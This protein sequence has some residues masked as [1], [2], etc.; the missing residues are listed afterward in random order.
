MTES[1]I[2]FL[3]GTV[4][5]TN[6][7]TYQPVSSVNP[8][9][10]AVS[11]TVV[12]GGTQNV[13]IIQVASAAVATGH[14]TASGVLR[15]ELPTDGTGVVGLNAGTAIIGK[16]AIDQTTPGTTNG[17]FLNGYET[18]VTSTPTVQNASY[19]SG[20]SVGGLNAVTLASFNGG[21]GFIQDVMVAS[22]GGSVPILTVYL[23]G[24]NPTG[25]TFTDKGTFSIAA[26]DVAKLIAAP[27]ALGLAA[28]TGTTV[29]F[30]Q[31]LNMG[32]PFIAGGSSASGVETIYYAL[33]SGSTFTPATTTDIVVF[34]GASVR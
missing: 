2:W 17:V 3:T 29:T 8:L 10:V 18:V 6:T 19:V 15:V 12:P 30:G 24:A 14:G 31:Q 28:P 23:F 9:P 21:S 27:F 1:D 13:N 34:I 22:K 16:V 33:C 4:N 20:N 25:S 32:L 26:A 7:P 5:A 11:G